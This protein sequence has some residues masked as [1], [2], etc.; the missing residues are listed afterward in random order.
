MPIAGGAIGTM[1][2]PTLLTGVR[3][4]DVASI[5]AIDKTTCDAGVGAIGSPPTGAAVALHPAKTVPKFASTK[6]RD[7]ARYAKA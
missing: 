5:G 7:V 4:V 2:S 1:V 6:S 3:V